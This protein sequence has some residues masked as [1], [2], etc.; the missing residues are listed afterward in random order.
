M[1]QFQ[2]SMF[3]VF[4]AF[5]LFPDGI[6][7]LFYNPAWDHYRTQISVEFAEHTFFLFEES[8]HL[9]PLCDDIGWFMICFADMSQC[10]C[11]LQFP[12]RHFSRSLGSS[13]EIL[14]PS[15]FEAPE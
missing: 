2:P 12:I 15:S 1:G 9:C 7:D 10:L 3:I 4:F 6:R 11:G 14:S 8:R 13:I 5:C